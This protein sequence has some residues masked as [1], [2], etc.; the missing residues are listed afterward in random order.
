MGTNFLEKSCQHFE[1]GTAPWT[2]LHAQG[3]PDRT[4]YEDYSDLLER[5]ME[6]A[7]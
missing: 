3:P 6:R 7:D 5:I 2:Y 4:G 1:E